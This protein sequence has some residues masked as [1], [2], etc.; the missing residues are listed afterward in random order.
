MTKEET[1]KDLKDLY[2]TI[3]T[4]AKETSSNDDA[5]ATPVEPAKPNW[6]EAAMEPAV[7]KMRLPC[8]G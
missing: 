8:M 6:M 3:T 5:S 7:V 1:V 2:A 4:A